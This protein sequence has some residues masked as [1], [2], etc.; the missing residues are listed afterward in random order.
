LPK[1]PTQPFKA[2][3]NQNLTENLDANFSDSMKPNR[4]TLLI[5]R[6]AVGQK[7]KNLKNCLQNKDSNFDLEKRHC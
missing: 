3:A 4:N 2:N 6:N 7:A 1:K 5:K